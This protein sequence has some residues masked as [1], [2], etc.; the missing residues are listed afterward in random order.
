M[1]DIIAVKEWLEDIENIRVAVKNE[2][3]HDLAGGKDNDERDYWGMAYYLKNGCNRSVY[4]DDAITWN[5]EKLEVEYV[6]IQAQ[7]LANIPTPEDLTTWVIDIEKRVA[8]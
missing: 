4:G 1:K 6:K 7:A 5:D 8:E 3:A 2:K